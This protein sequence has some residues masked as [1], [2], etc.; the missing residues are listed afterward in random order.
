MAKVSEAIRLV[1]FFIYSPNYSHLVPLSVEEKLKIGQK[2]ADFLVFPA[3]PGVECAR[4][5]VRKTDMIVVK[6]I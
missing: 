6:A 1:L 5:S 3:G 4:N 2:K